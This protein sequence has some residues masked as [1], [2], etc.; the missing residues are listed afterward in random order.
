[1]AEFITSRLR[2]PAP[3]FLSGFTPK[4]TYTNMSDFVP[5]GRHDFTKH[6]CCARHTPGVV[7]M[8]ATDTL[9]DYS[10][11]KIGQTHH[12]VSGVLVSAWGGGVAQLIKRRIR[13]QKIQKIRR[14]NPACVRKTHFVRVFPS[15]KRCADSQSVYPTPVCT[16]ARIR[17]ITYAR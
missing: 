14:S 5:Q 15:Q 4:H 16:P 8:H 9:H 1:M 2:G 7:C 17:I 12:H 13:N 10:S 3:D 6:E 11:L